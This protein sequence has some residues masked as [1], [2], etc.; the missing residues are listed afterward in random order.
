[1]EETNSALATSAALLT[2]RLP[3]SAEEQPDRRQ[4]NQA[5]K[6]VGEILERG[7]ADQDPGEVAGFVD[8]EPRG[9]HDVVEH[10]GEHGERDSGGDDG[11][12]PARDELTTASG[13]SER[14]REDGE[15][16][17][18]ENEAEG[19]VGHWADLRARNRTSAPVMSTIV[20]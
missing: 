13:C 16:D 3:P 10:G 15:C 6:G 12:P 5:G 17:R 8:H 14:D 7:L 11:Q 9:D 18:D 19:D 4:E 2:R 20:R 1:R